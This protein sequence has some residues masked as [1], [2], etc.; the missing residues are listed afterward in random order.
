MIDQDDLLVEDREGVRI[1]T[2]NRP[3]RRNALSSALAENLLSQ[4]RNADA[5]PSVKSI[6]LS[7]ADPVFC[8]GAD[9]SEGVGD[10]SGTVEQSRLS[11][12]HQLQT[13]PARMTKAVVAAVNGSAIGIGA[14]IVMAADFI[15]MADSA[16]MSF[17]ELQHG[18]VPTMVVPAVVKRVGRAMA[19]EIITLQT[20]ID[21]TRALSLGLAHRTCDESKLRPQAFEHARGFGEINSNLM[22]KVKTMLAAAE[23]HSLDDALWAAR[24]Y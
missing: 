18:M 22:S 12:F 14:S 19:F 9:L 21:A 15:V 4:L 7:G 17:P 16:H 23:T 5:D 24:M 6:L 10:I 3:S 11:T 13:F 20:P 8:A 2:L 1:L